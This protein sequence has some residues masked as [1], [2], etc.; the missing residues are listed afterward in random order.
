MRPMLAT[1][2]TTLPTGSGWIHE[3]KWDGM[4]VL[5]DRG[6]LTSRIENDVTVSFPELGVLRHLDVTLDGEVVVLGPQGPDFARLAERMHVSNPARAARLAEALPVTYLVFDILRVEGHDLL[7]EPL[8]LR[9]EVLAGLSLDEVSVQVPEVHTDG[10][11]LQAATLH[12]GLEGVVSKRLDS[13]Y[14]PGVRSPDWL[15]FPHRRRTSWVVGG[16]RPETGY[17]DR[18]GAVLVGEPTPDGLLYRGRVG[19]GIGPRNSA[20]LQ[21]VLA[22]LGADACPF[23]DEVPAVDAAGAHWVEPVLVV[24][25]ESLGLS[26]QGRLRQPAFIGIRDDLTPADLTP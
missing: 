17:A 8:S 11:A 3:I 15:K 21:E 14:Q 2:G 5:A 4:R 25:A 18:L 9:R 20:L 23:A 6:R 13:L 12:Q 24:D 10:P 26:S 1:R 16:W 22:P 19:S 7:R